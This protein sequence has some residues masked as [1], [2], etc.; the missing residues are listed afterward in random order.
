MRKTLLRVVLP[1]AALAVILVILVLTGRIGPIAPSAASID[2]E[3]FVYS[4]SAYEDADTA[5]GPYLTS[6]Q[7]PVIFKFTVHND[8]NVALASVNLTDTDITEFYT[9]EGC[10]VLAGFPT[11]LEVDETRTFY[12][13][14]DW[15]AGQHTDTGTAEGTPPAGNHVLD[16]DNANY[17]GQDESPLE[18]ASIDVEKCVYSGSAYEDADTAIGPYLTSAQSP[19]IFRFTIRNNGNVALTDVNLTDTDITTFYT[20]EGCT[21]LASFPTT[22]EVDETRTF[23]AE[24]DWAAGQ[25][26]DT[27]TA[28]A[29]PPTGNDVLDT[30]NA[31]YFG[32]DESPLEIVI[33]TDFLCGAC[34]R[35]HSEVQPEL[36]ERYVDT[37]KAQIE[38][39]L[40]GAMDPVLSMRG[41]EAALCARDQDKF[42]EYMDALFSAY[43]EE[44]DYTVFSVEALTD[45]AAELGLDEAA[46]T[47][48]LNGEAKQA[49]LDENMMMAQV[50][51]V[52]TLPAVLVGD[53]KIEGRKSLDVYIQA[54]E[55]ALAAQPAQ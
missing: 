38:I 11:T 3:K 8:G 20:D 2:V 25:H 55:T 49:E 16:T 13:E 50:D 18:T 45:L 40:L 41:A 26:T 33:Y 4:G 23:Y 19:V 17:F 10:T 12:A 35:L 52:S 43:G 24:L 21:V 42:L 34:E 48:C 54:I 29:I 36:R 39:R 51:G 15:A 9:D 53:S 37:G 30:D 44:E 7:N 5:T 47:S 6:A 1:V 32:Q 31:N 22:L 14:L 46:F 28:V 27:C